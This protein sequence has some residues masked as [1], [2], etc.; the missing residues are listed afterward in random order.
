MKF[1]VIGF[2]RE[3][4]AS[5]GDTE[6]KRLLLNW[7]STCLPRASNTAR[8]ELPTP[9]PA[10]YPWRVVHDTLVTAA[11]RSPIA[12]MLTAAI[13]LPAHCLSLTLQRLFDLYRS[14]HNAALP[15]RLSAGRPCSCE[16]PQAVAASGL[17]PRTSRLIDQK[18]ER[19]AQLSGEAS[20]SGERHGG[21]VHCKSSVVHCP[22]WCPR[23][24]SPQPRKPMAR[25][26]FG[27]VAS[28]REQRLGG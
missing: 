14:H 4:V 22:S 19:A 5:W 13:P 6:A 11:S 12:I 2:P 20:A 7:A 10:P 9:A 24:R 21:D 28:A 16:T 1:H 3:N 15:R 17:F 25:H 8:L 18:A 26:C 27:A 23:R